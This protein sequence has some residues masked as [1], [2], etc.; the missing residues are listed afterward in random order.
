MADRQ[1]IVLVSGA[2]TE[3]PTGDGIIGA[4]VT[5]ISN[6]SGLYTL[7]GELGYD[8]TAI[9]A[10]ASGNAALTDVGAAAASGNAALADA[11]TALASGNAG[12]SLAI[13]SGNAASAD[14][15]TAL[16]SGNAA[17]TDSAE[18]LASGNAALTD[19]AGKYDKTGGPISGT[20]R[21]QT[22]SYA[23]VRDEGLESGTITL[24]FGS[25][26][27]F[28][29]TLTGTSTLGAPTNASGG[30]SGSIFILQDGTGSRTLAYN[31]AFAF[32]GGTA[33]TLTTTASGQDQ[34]LYF[35]QDSSTIITTS[36]LNIS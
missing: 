2:F 13:A 22:Q 4:S 25:A 35:V 29:M 18:A 12:I 8:G 32:A 26:N 15:A 28:K 27:N 23:D 11:A 9:N 20:V 34:L 10:L 1:P 19:V 7:G 30:Q 31:A 36:I 17:L 3:L 14:A 24:D 16:A 5:L 33:P 6:P 21:V